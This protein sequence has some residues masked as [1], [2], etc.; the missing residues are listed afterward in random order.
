TLTMQLAR[1][2]WLEPE[3]RWK[4]KIEELAI[5]LHMERK[6]SKQQIFEFY[7][8]QVYLGRR[9]TFGI[10]GLAEGAQAYFGKD[11]SQIDDSE[12]STLAGLIQRRSY[13]NPFRYP[14]R[15]RQRRDVVLGLMLQNRYLSKAEY[16]A[17][18]D[19]PLRLRPEHSDAH[20]SQY[21]VD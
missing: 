4:R 19:K 3:K 6:L 16:R 8:N 7:A 13:Y 10:S 2:F 1:N 14:D 12:A 15:A 21:F 5:T 9:E 17:A 18:I 20:Q 11:L